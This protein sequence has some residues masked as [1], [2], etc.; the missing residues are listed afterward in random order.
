MARRSGVGAPDLPWFVEQV[1]V[2]WLAACRPCGRRPSRP[3]ENGQASVV[4]PL[5][6]VFGLDDA[7]R[8]GLSAAAVRHGLRTGRFV[9]LRRGL[10]C[11]AHVWR[12]SSMSLTARHVLETRAVWLALGRRGWASHYTAA[13]LHGLP[14][15]HGQPSAVT[16][17]RANRSDGR[18]R[19]PGLVLRTA[20]VDPVDIQTDWGM[21]VLSPARTS[22]D[23]ARVH[24]LAPALVL[25]DAA[26]ARGTA[27]VAE[28]DRIA[29]SMTGWKGAVEA[30]R[31]ARH[32]S[33]RRESP[34][35]S[36]S[37]AV[38]IDWELPLPDCNEW[39]IGK[40]RGGVRSDF[41]WRPY[42]MVG[43]ADGRVKYTD[44]RGDPEV[45]LAEE[46]ARQLRIEECRFVVVRWT[47]AEIQRDPDRVIDRI[48]RQSAV[49]HAMFGV[50][51]LVPGRP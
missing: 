33:G 28:L 23:V 4:D 22:L 48:V 30:R 13:L 43:E 5:P 34:N 35:E 29:A 10:F 14:V 8:S 42:R 46:K 19:L 36:C 40:G 37:F 41:V 24:G 1:A 50:P 32:A 27:T 31:V 21:S 39:V 6:L 9:R 25:A 17:S 3:A 16:I 49:A 20:T 12:R 45:V 38:F 26:L 51:L 44:P 11:D 2:P 7:A 47:G 18:H 15:P